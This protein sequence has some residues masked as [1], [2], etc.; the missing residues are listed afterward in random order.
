MPSVRSALLVAVFGVGLGALGADPTNA[1][2][3]GLDGPVVKAAQAALASGNVNLVL[4]WVR[5]SD[6]VEIRRAFECGGGTR[7]RRDVR[8]IQ[9]LR[10]GNV[11]SG[12][13]TS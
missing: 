1:H 12:H 9:P 8:C 11:R 13:A 4:I 3:D 7:V 6:E 2:C 5:A 10:R